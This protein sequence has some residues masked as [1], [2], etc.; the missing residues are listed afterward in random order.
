MTLPSLPP[1]HLTRHPLPSTPT[2]REL[3]EMS[4]NVRSLVHLP[5]TTTKGPYTG[6]PRGDTERT[7]VPK[8]FRKDRSKGCWGT[9]LVPEN[10][11]D[12][13]SDPQSI[14]LTTRKVLWFRV[15]LIYVPSTLSRTSGTGNRTQVRDLGES[16]TRRT[17]SFVRCQW[18][19]SP[20]A[21]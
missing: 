20:V 14:P 4:R 19:C 11:D 13:G 5:Q 15:P 9:F 7:E 12:T 18:R 17:V 8:F 6:P 10:N 1:S 16:R 2:F 21:T 3:G